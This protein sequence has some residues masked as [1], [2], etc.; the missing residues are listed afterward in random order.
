MIGVALPQPQSHRY[1]LGNSLARAATTIFET[2]DMARRAIDVSRQLLLTETMYAAPEFEKA[3]EGI[4][5]I[6]FGQGVQVPFD[7]TY[8]GN[9]LW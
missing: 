8:Q 5:I 7:S 9:H 1:V 6:F 2:A 3:S 4:V